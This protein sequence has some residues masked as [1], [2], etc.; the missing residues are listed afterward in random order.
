[1]TYSSDGAAQTVDVRADL[2]VTRGGRRFVAE[3]KTGEL[4]PR[5]ATVATR[6]QLLEYA[7]AF[8]VDGVLLVDPEAGRVAEVTFPM[9]HAARPLARPWLVL[10]LGVAVGAVA[11]MEWLGY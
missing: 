11:T 5:L 7:H 1:M 9:R 6:R 2:I 8:D 4:A 3:V 10:A